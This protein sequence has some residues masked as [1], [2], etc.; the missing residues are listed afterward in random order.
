[1]SLLSIL[2]ISMVPTFLTQKS[3]AVELLDISMISIRL[4]IRSFT[5]VVALVIALLL[6][7]IAG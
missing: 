2:S 4:S 3:T 6:R 5:L 7:V 1:M